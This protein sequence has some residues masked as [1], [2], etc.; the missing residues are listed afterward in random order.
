M[1]L[2]GNPA[3][4]KPG[5]FRFMSPQINI[6][7]KDDFGTLTIIREGSIYTPDEAL[8]KWFPWNP[9][10]ATTNPI[11]MRYKSSPHIVINLQKNGINEQILPVVNRNRIDDFWSASDSDQY[12]PWDT[13]KPLPLQYT[14]VSVREFGGLFLAELY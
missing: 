11:I 2:G 13:S 1:H 10:A 14:D 5:S 7:E 9:I 3:T 6:S 4:L 8:N 12:Y